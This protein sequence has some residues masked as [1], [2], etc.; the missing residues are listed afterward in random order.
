MFIEQVKGTLLQWVEATCFPLVLFIFPSLECG[1]PP[2]VPIYVALVLVLKLGQALLSTQV[3][4]KLNSQL[5]LKVAVSSYHSISC[6]NR[7]AVISWRSKFCNLSPNFGYLRDLWPAFPRESLA[8][9]LQL[10]FFSGKQRSLGHWHLIESYF[11]C[12]YYLVP[13]KK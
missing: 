6:E 2:S 11:R 8:A 12:H 7:D 4:P 13:V 3:L 1:S 10:G 5:F 9:F